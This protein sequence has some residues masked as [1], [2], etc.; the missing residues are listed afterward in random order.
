MKLR[1]ASTILWAL[2]GWAV[3][4]AFAAFLGVSPLI[5]PFVGAVWGAFVLIDPK[6]VLWSGR[7]ARG[8]RPHEVTVQRAES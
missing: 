3:A 6:H 2:A 1:I 8:L 4:G 5:G 7:D